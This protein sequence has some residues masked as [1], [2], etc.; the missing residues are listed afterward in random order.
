MYKLVAFDCDNTLLDS[1]ANIPPENIAAINKLTENGIKVILATGRNDILVKD[2]IL[3]TGINAPV[4]GCNGSSVR[5]LRTD[6]LI[7]F[8]PIPTASLS[9]VFDYCEKNGIKPKA[10]SM[11]CG[12]TEQ[13]AT[14]GTLA[15][16]FTKYKRVL[17]ND[18]TYKTLEKISDIVGKD[19]IIKVLAVDDNREFLLK[20]Q[21]ELQEID[22]IDVVMSNPVC[23]D[24][25]AKGI[26]KGSALMKYAE[27]CGIL[28]KET[29]SFG[30]SENDLSMF[31]VSGF[32]V[33]M[34][35][36]DKRLSDKVSMITDTNDNAG[37]A[38][39]LEKIF[40]E[41]FNNVSVNLH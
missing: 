28:P 18:L 15:S 3:E 12:Y 29:V 26:S 32:S 19:E 31:E 39:G 8:T 10:F 38:K 25:G 17:K 36:G 41:I 1:E 22:G 7:S 11:T 40:P 4:I 2:Y 21:R 5:N 6:E 13:K 37:V 35:N 16:I 14:S 34:G 23:I 9:A 30:D 20:T 33:L 24:I 27:M